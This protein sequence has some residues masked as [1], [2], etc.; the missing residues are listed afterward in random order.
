[1]IPGVGGVVKIISGL[2][3]VKRYQVKV[4]FDDRGH[5]SD[6]ARDDVDI[7]ELGG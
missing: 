2:S 6:D 1:V 5:E 7:I 3:G 4:L